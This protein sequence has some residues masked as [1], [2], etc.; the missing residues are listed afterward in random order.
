M[1]SHVLVFTCKV[2]HLALEA[3]PFLE[4]PGSI[5]APLLYPGGTFFHVFLSTPSQASSFDVYWM[6]VG[7]AH[8]RLISH[9]V[10]L[11][12]WTWLLSSRAPVVETCS[13]A[14][15]LSAYWK[16]TGAKAPVMHGLCLQPQVTGGHESGMKCHSQSGLPP[17]PHQCRWGL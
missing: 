4:N 8:G 13:T 17:S 1:K 6:A 7:P 10:Y 5:S 9:S 12:P 11:P 14:Q 2:T 15:K 16:I 3:S